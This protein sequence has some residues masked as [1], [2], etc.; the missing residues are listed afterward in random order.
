M[1]H[2]TLVE[3]A[4]ILGRH[5]GHRVEL[6]A[7]EWLTLVRLVL[8]R[9]GSKSDEPDWSWLE[10]TPLRRPGETVQ[11]SGSRLEAFAVDAGFKSSPVKVLPALA[12][13]WLQNSDDA[14]AGPDFGK[15]PLES[16]Q[17]DLRGIRGVSWEL[18]DRILLVVGGLAVYPLD[19][20]SQRIAARHGWI[21]ISADYDEWQAF[22]V[23]GPRDSG[24]PVED[25]SDWNSRI[26]REFCGVEP[27]CETCPLKGM[28]PE[29]GPLPLTSEE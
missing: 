15:R 13:W 9:R 16:W 2:N 23:G 6:P 12:R 20:G 26:G 10:D 28:L 27:Q 19:R 22:F 3:A 14:G 5:Y 17:R 25:L 4:R 11:Q 1:G 18:A 21:D 29:K 8:A 7:G 24:I